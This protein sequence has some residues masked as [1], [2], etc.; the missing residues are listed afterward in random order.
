MKSWTRAAVLIALCVGVLAMERAGYYGMRSI[1]PIHFMSGGATT[2]DVMKQLGYVTAFG[3]LTPV[4]GGALAILL[5]APLTA[6]AGVVIMLFGYIILPFSDGPFGAL[7]GV[8]IIALGGGLLKPTLY[9]LCAGELSHRHSY[10]RAAAFVTMYAAVNLSALLS[11][12]SA[13]ALGAATDT[14]PVLIG[15]AALIVLAFL[16]VL[17]VVVVEYML[18]DKRPAV[19][20]DDPPAGKAALLAVG[21]LIL[22]LPYGLAMSL[23]GDFWQTLSAA[24]SSSGR[25]GALLNLN[26]LV[27]V[28]CDALLLAVLV[29]LHF[30]RARFSALYLGGAGLCIL[31][32]GATP[33][34]LGVGMGSPS[35]LTVSA[36]IVLMAI[37]E[38]IAGPILFSVA[39]GHIPRRFAS[40]AAGVWLAA[41]SVPSYIVYAALG[42]SLDARTVLFALCAGATLV[43]GLLLLGV[44]HLIVRFMQ[45]PDSEQNLAAGG[46]LISA[47]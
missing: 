37:G 45:P 24:G 8:G 3:A 18:R 21:L 19:E 1:L 2:S 25:I 27:V 47:K 7:L 30:L 32:L 16:L 39:V 12:T 11:T 41:A 23:S 13:G 31:G 10:L 20:K 14:R 40:L 43:C 28:L 9:G 38:A 5:R 17:A 35:E 26:T 42:S 6:A 36:A 34:L 4:V 46:T 15:A 22:V 33:Y 44:T 29:I